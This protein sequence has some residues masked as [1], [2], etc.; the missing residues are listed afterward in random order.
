MSSND[1]FDFRVSPYRFVPLTLVRSSGV[2]ARLDE[3]TDGFDGVKAQLA[4]KAWVNNP[5]FTGAADFTACTSVT[6]PDLAI[7]DNTNKAATT[8]FVQQVVGASESLLPLQTGFT[9]KVLKTNGT[10]AYWAGAFETDEALFHRVL[11]Q[12]NT[13]YFNIGH[14]VIGYSTLAATCKEFVITGSLVC[15]IPSGATSIVYTSADGVNWISRALPASM[16]VSAVGRLHGTSR[17][18]LTP[19]SGTDGAISTDGGVTWAASTLPANFDTRIAASSTLFVGSGSA[20]GTYYTST[21]GETGSWT[22]RAT[23]MPASVSGI[24]ILEGDSTN[25]LARN[26]T[27]STTYYSTNG[28]SSWTAGAAVG[29]DISGS[30]NR[31]AFGAS[32]FVVGGNNQIAHSSTGASWSTVT[33]SANIDVKGVT[34]GDQFVAVGVNGSG[35]PVA[36]RSTDGITWTTVTVEAATHT[37]SDVAWNGTTYLAVGGNGTVGRFY[38]SPDAI[39]WTPV[40]SPPAGT[41]TMGYVV[42]DAAGSRWVCETSFGSTR[43]VYTSATGSGWTLT[44]STHGTYDLKYYNGAVYGGSGHVERTTDGGATWT[45]VF[46]DGS[47]DCIHW[48]G[49]MYLLGTPA[50]RFK[51]SFD[52]ATW[53]DV[54]YSISI[55]Y[56]CEGGFAANYTSSSAGYWSSTD[57]LV[58]DLKTGPAVFSTTDYGV[59]RNTGDFAFTDGATKYT[60][61][62]FLSW[63]TAALALGPTGYASV[64]VNGVLFSGAA[65]A[66]GLATRAYVSDNAGVSW[67]EYSAGFS[68]AFGANVLKNEMVVF[69]TKV[70]A[71]VGANITTFDQT[72]KGPMYS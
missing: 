27:G 30:R 18:L 61:S 33:P 56:G 72:M 70:L 44:N 15:L 20:T 37:L 66:S 32:K 64:S 48:T 52:L 69:G 54:P 68:G 62:D 43:D 31:V 13:G 59:N 12:D 35:Q 16:T 6:V 71:K 7:T 55:L 2:N 21:T 39:T 9:N 57:G 11:L 8:E 67:R 38:T 14:P 24:A 65:A 41:Y 1:F 26:E 10:Y 60:T 3:V 19:T 46:P 4:L 29:W 23:P 47:A 49:A 22:S 40:A 34:Y 50:S 25:I 36:A 45:D 28:G 51:A 58:W 53:V 17:I 5:V 63:T 42:W